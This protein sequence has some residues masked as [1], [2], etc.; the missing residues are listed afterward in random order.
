VN[1]FTNRKKCALAALLLVF[2]AIGAAQKA[3]KLT[4]PIVTA[5][6]ISLQPQVEAAAF[7]LK[8][9][10][11][12]GIYFETEFSG[13]SAPFIELFDPS[14]ALLPDGQY[15]FELVAEPIIPDG[16]KA[17]MLRAREAGDEEALKTLWEQVKPDF[18]LTQSGA[19]AIS[20]GLILTPM[21]EEP[22][23]GDKNIL[24]V[25]YAAGDEN[26]G[27]GSPIVDS[28][29]PFEDQIIGD[30]L[31][32]TR[33]IC[34]GFDCVNGEVFGFD[35]IK[36]KENNLR[37]KFE[38][39]SVG[40]FPT[41]DWQITA[42]DSAS[43]GASKLSFDDIDG[44][45][46]PFTVTAGAR[47]NAL[48]VDSQGDVGLGTSTPVVELHVVSGDSPTLRLEQNG[49]SGFAPQTWDLAG[50]ETSFFIRDATNGST[51]P[52]RIR[53]GAASNSLV[54][55]QDDDVGVGVLSAAAS[56]HVRRTDGTAQLLIEEAS[57]ASA[58][59]TL[60]DMSNE[61]PL[62]VRFQNTDSGTNWTMSND[63]SGF[64]FD[65]S[66][67]GGGEDMFITNS[68][69]FLIRP[70][71]VADPGLVLENNGDMEIGGVL[72]Q[73]SNK[74]AKKN[75]EPVDPRDVLSKVAELPL[76]KWTYKDDE[77]GSRHLG[78]M[79]QDFADAFGLGKNR[80]S[81]ATL[82]V[83][84]VAL[85]AIQGLNQEIAQ[86]DAAISELKTEN[87]AKAEAIGMLQ[88]DNEAMKKRLLALERMVDQLTKR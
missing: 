47:S 79:A 52:F 38:D 4:Q 1:F 31:I 42:N 65:S 21:E 34:V 44:G 35:T 29:V 10:G 43:G 64:I 86:R 80:E 71:G 82:D 57:A 88:N 51:L 17:D 5:D 55:D 20:N 16:V 26:N 22:A 45:R 54:I 87:Q 67:T 56:L 60:L 72:T 12:N 2:C 69:R 41:R 61:G 50:N 48:F 37:I 8:V 58:A 68:G 18:D 77:Q 85:A 73:N 13:L 70:N 75:F 33:S 40:A 84:G 76:K 36:L 9:K 3:P 78:P 28:D 63:A 24:P 23:A 14:G 53:P 7:T 62:R 11:P 30:D 6:L 39:T 59:R 32:V 46:T 19:F 27:G 74:H 83:S 81:I 25:Q 66:S 15:A 49:S